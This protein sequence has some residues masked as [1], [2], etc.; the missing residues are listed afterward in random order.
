MNGTLVWDVQFGATSDAP[1]MSYR[2]HRAPAWRGH[3]TTLPSLALNSSTESG[4]QAAYVS[5][6]GATEVD[7]WKLLGS[8][9]TLS[10]PR[11]LAS[12][13]RTGFETNMT[14]PS[15]NAYV[16]AAAF[17]AAGACLSASESASISTG[18]TTGLAGSCATVDLLSDE[19]AGT[20]LNVPLLAFILAISLAVTVPW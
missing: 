13:S 1:V 6:N 17:N 5:W 18:G 11:L 12:A 16:F 3:P 9:D 14:F 15:G 8:T 20:S 2:A 4:H 10:S 7:S 19:S